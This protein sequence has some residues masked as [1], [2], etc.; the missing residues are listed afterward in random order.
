MQQKRQCRV[1][2]LLL[3]AVIIAVWQCLSSLRILNPSMIPSP[4]SVLAAAIAGVRTGELTRYVAISVARVMRGFAFASVAGVIAGLAVGWLPGAR[5]VVNPLLSFLR[6]IPPI[7]WIPVLIM[8]FGIGEGSKVSVIAY[9]AFFP[10]FLNTETAAARI[11][12]SYLELAR[13]FRFRTAELIWRIIIPGSLGPIFAGLR[14]G[15]SSSW[16]ALVAAEM[17][18][19]A[20]GL[21]YMIVI[22]RELVRPDVMF[23]GIVVIGLLGYLTD[24]GALRLQRTIAP[25]S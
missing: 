5:T 9:A 4:T 21:G 7:A 14:L 16:R 22:S 12:A 8:W 2:G 13:V 6:Q 3:P 11:G 20:S 10:V 15:L 18:A 19:S 24:V 23:L 1:I 25:W 17:L